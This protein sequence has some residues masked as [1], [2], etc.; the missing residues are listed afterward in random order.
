MNCPWSMIM[1]L[2]S[3]D[4][5]FVFCVHFSSKAAVSHLVEAPYPTKRLRKTSTSPDGEH[6]C[7]WGIDDPCRIPQQ[8]VLWP[9]FLWNP[10]R[11]AAPWA[12]RHGTYPAPKKWWMV[13]LEWRTF[14]LTDDF[15]FWKCVF[16][17]EKRGGLF[18]LREKQ[19]LLVLT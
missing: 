19:S 16:L 5:A 11:P 3:A 8:V 15:H 10:C 2:N 9:R 13:W 6:H 14:P 7:R 18:S 1:A 17:W 12:Q 4:V